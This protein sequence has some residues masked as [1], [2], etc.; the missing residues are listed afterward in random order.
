M[1]S[2][3]ITAAAVLAAAFGVGIAAQSDVERAQG[4]IDAAQDKGDKAAY[5]KLL[6]EDFAWVTANGRL[7]DKKTSVDNLQPVKGTPGRNADVSVRPYPGGAVMV[8]TRHQPDGSQVRVLR[9]WVQRGNQWQLAAHQGVALGNA[10]A[11]AP[12]PSS[13]MPPNSGPAADIKAV[14]AAIDALQAGNAKNDAKNFAASVTD[15]FVG[16]NATGNVASKQDRIAG[17][18][19][20]PNPPAQANVEETSTRIYGD[21][22]VTNRVVKTPN[23]RRRQMIVHAKQGGKWLRAGVIATPIATGNPAGQ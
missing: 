6:V 19:K 16:I 18:A 23:D 8:F 3:R 20:G 13:P 10:P 22:A 5:S 11:A 17:I 1:S 4:A 15:G 7:R 12:Q 9:L 2:R 21:L 14:E